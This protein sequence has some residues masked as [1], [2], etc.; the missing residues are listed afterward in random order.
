M[1][2]IARPLGLEVVDG[3]VVDLEQERRAGV[4][5]RS[6]QVLDDLGLP[7][8]DD[9]APARQIAER[10]A[11]ALAVE[12]ELDAV[13]DDP[14]ALHALPDAGLDEQVGRP[15]LE[16]AGADAVLDVLAAAV[17]EHDRLDALAFEQARERQPGRAG[18]DD[19]DLRPHPAAAASAS[20]RTR[21]AIA[22]APFAA[23]TPQ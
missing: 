22:N 19:A 8:D 16:H 17:L 3:H 20:S 21:C 12:L 10:N 13:V 9:A 1:N 15:L 11:V 14:L 5:P 6:D 23:G 7:V 4:E 2:S 18:A